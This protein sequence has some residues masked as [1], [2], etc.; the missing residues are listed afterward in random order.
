MSVLL[1]VGAGCR[2]D[3]ERPA[4]GGG[5]ETTAPVADPST[6]T[7]TGQVT[8]SFGTHV[9]QLGTAP[10]EPVLVVLPTP[11]S[12]RQGVRLEVIGRIT[13]CVPETLEGELG[14]D[15]GPEVDVLEGSTC[16]VAASVRSL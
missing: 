14:V 4:A 7:L 3:Q 6:V 8:R 15:L 13:T 10:S 9:V 2:D 12:F 11:S 1:V 5:V 16:L